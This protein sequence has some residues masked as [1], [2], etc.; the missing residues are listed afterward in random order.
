LPTDQL[1]PLAEELLEAPKEL[2]LTAPELERS[3]GVG[4][5][6]QV[7][8][9]CMFLAGLYANGK[10]V[11]RGT[12][13]RRKAARDVRRSGSDAQRFGDWRGQRLLEQ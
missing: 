5:A 6:D 4:I 12:S 9:T 10:D 11:R 13:E 8:D 1:I 7:D 2:I 3:E